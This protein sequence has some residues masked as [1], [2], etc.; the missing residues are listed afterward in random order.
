MVSSYLHNWDNW[1]NWANLKQRTG[2]SK[3]IRYAA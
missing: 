2:N 3:S 1:D